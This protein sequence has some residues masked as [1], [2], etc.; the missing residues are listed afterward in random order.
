MRIPS[1]DIP[2][3]DLLQDVI[4]VVEA[5]QE[6]A[7]TFQDIAHHIHKV[8]RQGRYYR[9]AAEILGFIKN[10]HNFSKLTPLGKTFLSA[11]SQEKKN[12]LL[13]AI[14]S[15]RVFQRLL[16][17]IELHPEGVSRRQVE[18]FMSDVTEQVGPTM[19]H[20]RVSSVLNW[21]ES[22]NLINEDRG[23]YKLARLQKK[24]P[25]IEYKDDTEPL[26]PQAS[27]LREYQEI[28]TRIHAAEAFIS[29]LRNQA[30]LERANKAHNQLTN[31]IAERI[32]FAGGLPRSNQF[33]DLA[34]RVGDQ[35]YIFEMKSITSTN[36]RA[37][38]RLGLSQ[39]LEYRYL[40]RLSEANL[41][42]VLEKPLPAGDCW[43]KDYLEKDRSIR[44][45]WDG[46]K[47][48]YASHETRERL[49]FLWIS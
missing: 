43:M 39:L 11:S 21:L 4:Y 8:D 44:L 1:S 40:Q 35:A 29:V 42:L 17:F 36:A 49:S 6:G 18:N 37:Q 9:L 31:L 26:L 38:V 14:L 2:Q 47:E 16:P 30:A 22:A 48:F 24:S 27:D 41:V 5:V 23:Q 28:Q 10:E 12:I 33:I 20:R 15:S 13:S 25:L 3:A 32:R 19:L 7:R 34:T 46:N 45:I